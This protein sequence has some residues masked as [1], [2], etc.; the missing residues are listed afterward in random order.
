M[1]CVAQPRVLVRTGRLR[2]PQN[3]FTRIR[4]KRR[5]ATVGQ[6]DSGEINET[7]K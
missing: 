3:A 2:P 1:Q 5:V 6:I 7:T 4:G